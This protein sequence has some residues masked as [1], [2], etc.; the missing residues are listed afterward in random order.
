MLPAFWMQAV[1]QTPMQL[2]GERRAASALAASLPSAPAFS[3]SSSGR[4][5]PVF[6]LIATRSVQALI[7]ATLSA[8]GSPEEAGSE[9]NKTA[10]T[11]AERAAKRRLCVFGLIRSQ[12]ILER[13]PSLRRPEPCSDR[14]KPVDHRI[15]LIRD[16]ELTEVA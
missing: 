6:S 8:V 7:A 9:S 15:D 16:F 1:D 3:S 10:R 11:A 13:H 2:A 5:G 4:L 14:K 12:S